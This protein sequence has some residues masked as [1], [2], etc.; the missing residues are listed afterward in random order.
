[1][2]LFEIPKF[3]VLNFF[4]LRG[5]EKFDFCVIR[6]RRFWTSPTV[7]YSNF[8]STRFTAKIHELDVRRNN[9]FLSRFLSNPEKWKTSFFIEFGFF[10]KIYERLILKFVSKVVRKNYSR[11]TVSF[12]NFY[13]NHFLLEKFVFHFKIRI[14]EWGVK[15]NF[16][17]AVDPIQPARYF[18][19]ITWILIF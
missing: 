13:E 15:K 4:G 6:A 1:M 18:S 9:F 5:A 14:R 12:W 11:E 10:S 19:D 8:A 2:P 17:V 16:G 7:Y 3:L